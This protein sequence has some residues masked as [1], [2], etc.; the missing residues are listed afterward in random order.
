[1]INEPSFITADALCLP[2]ESSSVDLVVTHPPYLGVDP[3]RYKG[4]TE[5]QI[6]FTAEQGTLLD[7]L[8]GA[9]TEMFRVL[10]PNGSLA[11]CIG[12]VDGILHRYVT[13]VLDETSFKLMGEVVWAYS[14]IR[15]QQD[16]GATH[17]TWL[18]FAK[19]SAGTHRN[20]LVIQEYSGIWN[21]PL[22]NTGSAID[23]QLDGF[24]YDTFPEEIAK[25]FILMFTQ[26]GDTVLDP[27]GG[28]GIAATQAALLGR[29]GISADISSDQTELAKK[30]FA[31]TVEQ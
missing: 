9:T 6:T 31:F 28:S 22:D 23:Q 4:I 10:K 17:A 1:M 24:M 14:N 29:H 2:L 30:R 12:N 13:R 19:Q 26:L 15:P 20:P 11:I 21:L 7:R 16:L 3:S 25:R 18:C 27:F 5:Q 8:V